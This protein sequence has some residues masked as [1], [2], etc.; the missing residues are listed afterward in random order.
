[1]FSKHLSSLMISLRCFHEILSGQEVDELLHLLMAV[2]NSSLEKEFH[3]KYDLKGSS[4]NKE[5]STHQL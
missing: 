4:S 2:M 5:A 1:M 3:I